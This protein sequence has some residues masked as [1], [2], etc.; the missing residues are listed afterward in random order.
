MVTPLSLFELNSLVRKSLTESFSD[1]YWVQAEISDVHTN[2]VSGHCYLEFIE[3]N[4]RNNTL[5]AK[6][7]GTIWANVFQLLKPYF[8]ESTGQPFVSGIKVLVKV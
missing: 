2:V 7:R 8:E 6:A 5:I 4:P 1:T 3:K